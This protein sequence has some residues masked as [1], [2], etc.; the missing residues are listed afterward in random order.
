MEPDEFAKILSKSEAPVVVTARGGF[1]NRKFQY[2]TSY[3]GLFFFTSSVTPL[4]LPYKA[5][6]VSARSIWIP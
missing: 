5:E 1:L 3:K 6:Q 4:N 2:L